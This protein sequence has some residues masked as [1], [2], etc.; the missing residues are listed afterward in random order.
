MCPFLDVPVRG[1]FRLVCTAVN[2]YLRILSP[3]AR[4]TQAHPH[5][6]LACFFW[7]IYRKH[8]TAQRNQPSTTEQNNVVRADHSAA[9]QAKA[10]R[11]AETHYVVE[12]LL[13]L[14]VFSKRTKTSKSAQPQK[15]IQPHTT[16]SS[17][18]TFDIHE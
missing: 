12:H 7:T 8:S 13:Q 2:A 16:T 9:M 3:S 14:A 10:D 15:R 11:D 17:S 6:E 5:T 18:S 4:I 1:R